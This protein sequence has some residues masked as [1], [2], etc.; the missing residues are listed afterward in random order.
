M[1]KY[2]PASLDTLDYHVEEAGA[3][4]RLVCPTFWISFVGSER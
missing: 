1:D 4:K 2:R 3:L